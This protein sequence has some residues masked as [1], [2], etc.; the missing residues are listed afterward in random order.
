METPAPLA[1]PELEELLVAE[2]QL[3][4]S[5]KRTS[6]SA[7]RT[8]IAVA[9]LPLSIVSVLIA[10]SRMWDATTIA[11]L[12]IPLLA[13]CAALLLFSI[14]LMARAVLRI[15]HYDLLLHQ[16]RARNGR[17]RELLD[18]RPGDREPTPGRESASRPGHARRRVFAASSSGFAVGTPVARSPPHRSQ[19]AE[20]PHWAPAA[21]QTR[22]RSPGQG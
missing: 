8:G 15:R 3:L 10:T 5:E 11:H 6:L 7:I 13:A 4:L 14:Y 12:L 2:A 21:G 17:V 16:L 22:R 19:R 1:D 9:A 18:G 20:L